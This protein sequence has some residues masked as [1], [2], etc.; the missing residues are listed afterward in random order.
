MDQ[1]WHTHHNPV[2]DDKFRFKGAVRGAKLAAK[3]TKHAADVP[4]LVIDPIR[5]SQD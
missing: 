1:E 3:L 4:S 5:W 2:L